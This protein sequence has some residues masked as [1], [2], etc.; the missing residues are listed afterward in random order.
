MTDEGVAVV[1]NRCKPTLGSSELR[2][3]FFLQA[4]RG[5]MDPTSPLGILR[6]RY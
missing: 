3:V 5:P 6:R 1:S 2:P 4:P